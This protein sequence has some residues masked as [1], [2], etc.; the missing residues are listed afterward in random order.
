MITV[1]TTFRIILKLLFISYNNTFVTLLPEG[2]VGNLNFSIE[3]I[4]E[5]VNEFWPF[6]SVRINKVLLYWVYI[7]YKV[8]STCQTATF[9]TV[10]VLQ[11]SR[12]IPNIYVYIQ[13]IPL[14]VGTS[15]QHVS[16][17]LSGCPDYPKFNQL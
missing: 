12:N 10:L 17:T 11:S 5:K 4:S 1:E 3:I 16:T 7:I 6:V 8:A 15:V 13:W 14:N 9:C 2:T